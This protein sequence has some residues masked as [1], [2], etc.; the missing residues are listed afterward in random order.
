MN[1]SDLIQQL[2]QR[3]GLSG[4]GARSVVEVLFGTA[5]DAGLIGAALRAGDRVQL[6]GFG[7]FEARERK[8]RLG[9]NPHTRERIV[10]PAGKAPVFRAGSMLRSQLR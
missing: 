10:I 9:R 6:A 4:E 1:K 8:Q 3:T 7:T 5:S 2:G